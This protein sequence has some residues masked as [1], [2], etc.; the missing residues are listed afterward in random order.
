VLAKTFVRPNSFNVEEYAAA[1]ISGVLHNDETTEVRVRFA[2]RVAKAA[3][4]AQ[5]VADRR[6]SKRR[7][8]SVEIVYRVADVDELV[9]WV[10]GWGAQAEIAAPKSARS[11]IASLAAEIGAK[12]AGAG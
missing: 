7:D 2:P 10:L 4:A 6:V 8:G 9:R 11:R 3:T 12:Y 5:I 1:S